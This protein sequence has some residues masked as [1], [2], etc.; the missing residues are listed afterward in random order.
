MKTKKCNAYILAQVLKIEPK[1]SKNTQLHEAFGILFE[2]W[3]F[4]ADLY[5]SSENQ[6]TFTI[7]RDDL[8]V[9]QWNLGN[10]WDEKNGDFNYN[11]IYKVVLEDIIKRRLFKR[12][13]LGKK[14]Q[15]EYDNKVAEAKKKKVIEDTTSTEE[16]VVIKI[17]SEP[18]IEELK[19][20]R[21]NLTCKIYNW[22]KK[23]KDA[24]EME[25]ELASVKEQL[26]K[27]TKTRQI[28]KET[29]KVTKCISEK[30]NS[31]KS[32]KNK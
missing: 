26:Q 14:A 9:E 11:E 12:P 29:K 30:K 23:G 6:T 22:K 15:K 8:K 16:P 13:K 19:K 2:A 7:Y 3:Q 25:Q 20:K 27:R 28:S 1:A 24:S 5:H 18:S 10:Q 32:K 17:E 31:V 4:E 21:D